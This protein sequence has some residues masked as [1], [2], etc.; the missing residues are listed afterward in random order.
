MMMMMMKRPQGRALLCCLVIFLQ[1][2]I[3][4]GVL[5]DYIISNSTGFLVANNPPYA[6]CTEDQGNG[7][8]VVAHCASLDKSLESECLNC[9]FANPAATKMTQSECSKCFRRIPADASS[10]FAGAEYAFRSNMP[11]QC[12]TDTLAKVADQRA[13]ENSIESV[14]NATD[15]IQNSL[16]RVFG[17]KSM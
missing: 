1:G 7:C 6:Q 4:Q 16:N 3:I 12:P 14:T 10:R 15:S 17:R 9:G 2:C 11:K 8:A 5:G 13:V